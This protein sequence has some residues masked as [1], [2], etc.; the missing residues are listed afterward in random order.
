MP[1]LTFNVTSN[2]IKPTL[3]VSTFLD[4]SVT[5]L[6]TSSL[7]VSLTSLISSSVFSE[8]SNMISV[9]LLIVTVSV[10]AFTVASLRV[11]FVAFS[12]TV[13]VIFSTLTS[14]S[15]SLFLLTAYLVPT[16]AISLHSMRQN[17]LY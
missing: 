12:S 13:G 8:D 2:G 1:F 4:S 11:S 9:E 7:I 16:L 6:T 3:F 17:Q 14:G 15:S 10:P 5:F